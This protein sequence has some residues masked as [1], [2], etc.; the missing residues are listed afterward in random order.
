MAPALTPPIA[1]GRKISVFEIFSPR[2]RSRSA[3]VAISSPIT[4]APA[5]ASRI[6]RNV[7][8]SVFWKFGEA[9]RSV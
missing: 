4:I 9:S 2:G 7:L 6:H 1:I 8:N 5:G 3:R